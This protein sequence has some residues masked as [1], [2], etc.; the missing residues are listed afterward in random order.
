MKESL[1]NAI[2]LYPAKIEDIRII[3]ESLPI[4]IQEVTNAYHNKM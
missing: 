4:I 3:A 2:N 1:S